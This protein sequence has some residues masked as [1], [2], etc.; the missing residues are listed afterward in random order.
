MA[1]KCKVYKKTSSNNALTVYLTQRDFL[2]DKERQLVPVAGVVQFTEEQLRGDKIFCLVNL[3]YRY[4][5]EEDEAMV[6]TFERTI[7]L[8]NAP[9]NINSDEELKQNI[10]DNHI[11]GE[12]CGEGKL[13]KIL[14]YDEEKELE[15]NL[16]ALPERTLKQTIIEGKEKTDSDGDLRAP[17]T[18]SNME[19]VIENKSKGQ[20]DDQVGCSKQKVENLVKGESVIASCM[21]NVDVKTERKESTTRQEKDGDKN[22]QTPQTDVTAENSNEIVGKQTKKGSSL[23]DL[24]ETSTANNKKKQANS[25]NVAEHEQDV[26]DQPQT[27]DQ[28][29]EGQSE[30]QVDRHCKDQS[31]GEEKQV[32]TQTVSEKETN[33]EKE[34]NNEKEVSN[35]THLATNGSSNN[36]SEKQS[37]ENVSQ[38]TNCQS[39]SHETKTCISER[40][41]AT[42]TES[43]PENQSNVLEKDKQKEI[44][45]ENESGT[46]I[47]APQQDESEENPAACNNQEKDGREGPDDPNIDYP[48]NTEVEA[49]AQDEFNEDEGRNKGKLL[50]SNE[51]TETDKLP[52]EKPLFTNKTADLN[53]EGS[54]GDQNKIKAVENSSQEI[55]TEGNSGKPSKTPDNNLEEKEGR[56]MREGESGKSSP[57][58]SEFGNQNPIKVPNSM[59]NTLQLPKNDCRSP[60]LKR[61]KRD[62]ARIESQNTG[63]DFSSK[64]NAKL[65]HGNGEAAIKKDAKES[66]DVGDKTSDSLNRNSEQENT[67]QGFTRLA[68]HRSRVIESHPLHDKILQSRRHYL[69]PVPS[70][71]QLEALTPHR[72]CLR[73]EASIPEQVKTT[74]ENREDPPPASDIEEKPTSQGSSAENANPSD[75]K[76]KAGK[77]KL[78]NKTLG[79]HSEGIPCGIT[80]ESDG[81]EPTPNQQKRRVGSVCHDVCPLQQRL[82]EKLQ[83]Q[84]ENERCIPFSVSIP[85]VAPNSVT[86]IPRPQQSLSK[87]VGV[88]YE[89]QVYTAKQAREEP[90]KYKSTS[91]AVRKL[92]LTPSEMTSKP[93]SNLMSVKTFKCSPGEISISVALNKDI[94]SHLEEIETTV[95]LNNRSK[96]TIKTILCE[97]VQHVSIDM[98]G[99]E[100]SRVVTTLESRDGCPV[101][102]NYKLERKFSLI[103]DVR[104]NKTNVGVAILGHLRDA[105]CQLA[106]T[107]LDLTEN[108][109]NRD[110]SIVVTYFVRISLTFGSLSGLLSI[111]H[112][113]Q[114]LQSRPEEYSDSNKFNVLHKLKGI[115]DPGKICI[116][117][118]A[119][120]RKLK[121]LDL[122]D[123]P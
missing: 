111:E 68:E 38:K 27:N 97:V 8:L 98:T 28:Q 104:Y 31:T 62:K 92:Q 43:L 34:T 70:Q 93:R 116:E 78:N 32:E 10:D 102:P 71:R 112:P 123:G 119:L 120:L 17:K 58:R 1:G 77:E 106:S 107:T 49:L 67:T 5:R 37:N 11:E 15:M 72:D 80:S 33:Y 109:L 76:N 74:D 59:P 47:N 86:L 51:N 89:L 122:T 96:K 83:A 85:A 22:N 36:N 88:I 91:F 41:D 46:P 13:A 56:N 115:N 35:D 87:P 21:S 54:T 117:E 84:Q 108:S 3:T 113:I 52:S 101:L 53:V 118:F 121:S 30:T 45:S 65:N 12:V 95:S 114:L 14:H 6:H 23:G 40:N 16:D 50:D 20:Q 29:G 64:N 18:E 4:G 66:D 73:R 19:N 60:S 9:I 44:G 75:R 69:L 94:Y 103:P 48:K 25:E 26:K 57:A 105:D 110:F 24:Q 100:F 61:E 2:E 39:E 99:T 7:Q 63:E 79:Q 82:I 42:T 81:N 90:A 55:C